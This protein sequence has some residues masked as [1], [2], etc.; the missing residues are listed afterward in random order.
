MTLGSDGAASS[1]SV[2][3][4]R[5]WEARLGWDNSCSILQT[6]PDRTWPG[7]SHLTEHQVG[8]WLLD[9]IGNSFH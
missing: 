2:T 9:E 4:A 5:G 8:F 6:L 1:S 7:A 3:G